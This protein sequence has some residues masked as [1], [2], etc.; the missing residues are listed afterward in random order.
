[1]IS[2]TS[3]W[4]CHPDDCRDHP[5][6]PVFKKSFEVKKGLLSA[7]MNIS[8]HGIYHTLINGKEVTDHLFTPGFTSYY[9]R[10]QYQEY[11]ITDLLG[12]GENA[13]LTTVGDGSI[14]WAIWRFMDV[15]VLT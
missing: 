9:H 12:E 5:L 3:K 4:I 14:R 11:D 8:A 10:I 6:I 13:W 1:M 2:D 15:T 7:S